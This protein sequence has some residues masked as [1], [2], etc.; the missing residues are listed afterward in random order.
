M[1]YTVHHVTRFHYSAPITESVMDVYM[2]PRTE[3]N[4]RCLTYNLSVNPRAQIFSHRDYLGNIVNHFDIPRPHTRLT[5]TAEALV[6]IR[7]APELPLSLDADSW[8]Q[9]DAE[10]AQSDFWDMLMPSRFIQMTPLVHQLA[11]ELN[12][13]QRRD[14]PLSLLR[15]LNTAIYKTFDYDQKSTEV[16][17]PIDQALENRKGV[18]Q[19]F[20]HIMTALVR[21]LNIPCR[22]VSGYLFTGDKDRSAEDATHAWVE[23]YLPGLGW[24]GLDPTNN[25]IVADRHIRVAIGRDYADVP[26]S[27]GV[28]KGTAKTELTVSVQ[29]RPA[30]EMAHGDDNLPEPDWPPYDGELE[31]Q[32]QQQQQQQ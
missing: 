8:A 30:N 14:D 20:A 16:D 31:D 13:E 24:V 18:C 11:Q 2:H 25:L 12:V 1:N 29:V 27:R 6:E 5:I 4:Q 10:V 32:T 26:P 9:L 7:P 21:N 3:G 23:A 17:S 19:D 15:E 22:Y 28:F